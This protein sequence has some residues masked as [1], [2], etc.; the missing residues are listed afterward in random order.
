MDEGQRVITHVL[1]RLGGRVH[2]T[3]LVK[4]VYLVDYVHVQHFGSTATGFKYQW[5]HY[6]P[7]AVGHIIV[8]EA[9][10]LADEDIVHEY[11]QKSMYGGHAVLFKLDE[12]K[13]LPPLDES[14]LAVIDDVVAQFGRMNISEI[15]AASKQTA[16]FK[17]A[18]QYDLLVLEQTLQPEY[19][20][21]EDAAAFFSDIEKHPAITLEQ[22]KSEI[23]I[24]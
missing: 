23:G 6:G 14:K 12:L 24:S 19:T 18:R 8:H 7:N 15:T 20:S 10:K 1:A 11:V 22:L 21:A 9:R 17:N 13:D 16:P 4:T 3:K 5:D 2:S